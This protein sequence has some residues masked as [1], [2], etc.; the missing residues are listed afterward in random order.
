MLSD[1]DGTSDKYAR[2][3]ASWL[4]QVGWIKKEPK[5]VTS[6]VA[7][8]TYS[9]PIPQA[10]TLTDKGR[11]AYRRAIGASKYARIKKNVF[12]EMLATKE[13][14]RRHLR[15]RRALMIKALEGKG[16]RTLGQIQAE[17]SQKGIT[18]NTAT[19]ADD[20]IGLTNIGLDIQQDANGS[21]RLNDAI[22][23]LTI[24]AFSIPDTQPSANPQESLWNR[25]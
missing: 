19:I 21:Y 14:S 4:A 6:V 9:Y 2:M 17:L 8:Q 22:D 23:R 13:G 3:I 11:E 15:M 5:T 24:P 10:Y 12:F 16:Y 20:L 1:W 25:F 18:I 7:G